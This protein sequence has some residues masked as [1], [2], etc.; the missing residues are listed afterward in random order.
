MAKLPAKQQLFVKEYIVD[1]NGTQAY[2]R[3]GYKASEEAARRNASRLL[4]KADI[5]AAIREAM[6]AREQRTEV[7][8]D[9][10]V[11]ELAK[12]AFADIKDFLAF[13]TGI[14]QVGYTDDGE[15]IFDYAQ[16]IKVKDSDEVDG[17]VI[18]E[19]SL[20]KDGT[21]K[22]KLHDKKAALEMLGKHLGMF[23]EHQEVSVTDK[24]P[25]APDMKNLSEEELRQLAALFV[26][27]GGADDGDSNV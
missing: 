6:K 19:V 20:S 2:L 23:I 10:V 4:T 15:P 26:K 13:R 14:T 12:I 18:S 1:L 3:A 21:F 22:F 11:K 27:N 8:A 7:S 25:R 17:A 5:Q 24:T 16:I 9:R